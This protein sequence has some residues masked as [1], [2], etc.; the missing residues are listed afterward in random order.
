MSASTLISKQVANFSQGALKAVLYLPGATAQGPT[1]GYIG[2][3]ES[4]AQSQSQFDAESAARQ[5]IAFLQAAKQRLFALG[6]QQVIGPIDGDTWHRYRLPLAGATGLTFLEPSYPTFTSGDFI[7]AGMPV[8][9]T[10]STSVVTDL[11]LAL[12]KLTEAETLDQSHLLRVGVKIRCIRLRDF[13]S[14]LERLYQFSIEA[15]KHNFLYTDIDPAAFKMLYRP[16]VG[17]LREELVLLAQE[18]RADGKLLGVVLVVPDQA[19]R[20]GGL[21][22]RA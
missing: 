20:S 11:R 3:L 13:E 1:P 5:R 15:F 9:A 8:I 19:D 22:P 2:C 14:E 12:E 10:Y 17:L 21:D 18:D 4:G 6:A 7:A 16:L